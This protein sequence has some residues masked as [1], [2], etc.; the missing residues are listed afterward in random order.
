MGNYD[1]TLIFDTS[2]DTD[3]IHKGVNE[4]RTTFENLIGADIVGNLITEGVQYAATAIKD[5]AIEGV[6]LAS[7]LQEVE[8]VVDTTFGSGA[9]LIYSWAESADE[10]FGISELAAQQYTGT[11][12]SMLKSM[13]LTS[14][15]AQQMSTDM[16]GLAG[17]MASF[18]NL[19]V[20]TSFEKIRSGISG[21]TEPL[22][23]LGINMSVANLE[24]YALSRGIEEAYSAM[25]Q[26]EQA[27]LR[28]NYLMSVTADAQGDF[29]KTSEGYA[30]QQ[31]I[32]EMNI[33][34][35]SSTMGEQLLPIVNESITMFNEKLPLAEHHI[36]NIG[37]AFASAAEFAIENGTA[38]VTVIGVVNTYR[39]ATVAAT[40]A[41][42]ALNAVMSANPYTLIAGG[43]VAAV[44]AILNL[45][46]TE[47]KAAEAA[48][49]ANNAYKEQ[50]EVVEDINDELEINKSRLEELSQ[51]KFPSFADRQEIEDL[52]DKN[53]QL[54][55]QLALEKEI[56]A[57]KQ[58][59]A[60]KATARALEMPLES[61]ERKLESYKSSLETLKDLQ[62]EY[63]KAVSEGNAENIEQ[64]KRYIDNIT[65]YI[66][67]E[68]SV[69]M[70]SADEAQTLAKDLYGVTEEGLAAQKIISELNK[71]LYDTLNLG[72][73]KDENSQI[74]W[75]GGDIAA[76]Q[77]RKFEEGQASYIAALEAG[78]AKVIASE[79]QYVSDT[80]IALS[81][82]W[83][84]AEHNYAIGAIS[85][86]AELYR[87]KQQLWNEYGN[88][89]L[90][91]HWS[92]YEDLIAYQQDYAER[93]KSEYEQQLR[94][95]WTRIDQQLQLGL[96]SEEEAY[97]K[98]LAFI[99]K[100][101][102]EY[103][104]EWYDYYKEVYD[105]Q[106]NAADEQLELLKNSMQEQVDTV[107]E[108]LNDILSRYKDT[109]N[110][111]Q[112]NIDGYKNKLLSLGEA[113]SV[114]EN[115]D[116]SKTLRVNNLKE[117]MAEMQKY[118]SYIKK[119]KSQ[120]ASAGLL[121]ELTS[122]DGEEGFE[123]AK[124]LANMSSADFA[125]VNDY[126]NERDELAKEMAQEL[127][128]P[129]IDSLNRQLTDDVI[130]KFGELPEAVRL[131]GVEAVTAFMS[132][133]NEGNLSEQ[134]EGFANDF[135]N[136]L[137]SSIENGFS[138]DNFTLDFNALYE[139]DTYSVGLALG[140]DFVDG[141]NAAFEEL[142]TAVQTEQ[143]KISAEYTSQN[144]SSYIGEAKSLSAGDE[145]II[146][147]NHIDLKVDM[148]GEK[149]AEKVIEY[150]EILNRG[151]G[152]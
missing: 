137:S 36:E 70:S 84:T 116:G 48:E 81:Q 108:G 92:Y 65:F 32:F 54:E 29:A 64:Y 40:A 128:Q 112:S 118:H 75:Y 80:T 91:E 149:V 39:I 27:M 11:L 62:N 134:L 30:N 22:K 122:M 147:E 143:A 145:R 50:V 104:D 13:G 150:K 1:G 140:N 135:V 131:A 59:T 31:R 74:D 51:L 58:G 47:K 125:E 85:S 126:Y 33:Q 106:Q 119:L 72:T 9:T 7:S 18:Y 142:Q 63:D 86:E 151:K 44:A 78:K 103:S 120:G 4:I 19:D 10:S 121:A 42:T 136:E 89:N 17:D 49:T 53:E 146:L 139:Q 56:L 107:S 45:S 124:N 14:A 141:F 26:A 94:S 109:Y 60:D 73:G 20:S 55:I 8:N 24:A 123:F 82:A 71:E 52:K 16:T 144:R 3:G 133:I 68:K 28:Y 88:A 57:T 77:K 113:F 148:D 15:Q 67:E 41:Q 99:Q 127:Y 76:E 115:D 23:Q 138:S 132:G 97:K 98:K 130:A 2:I 110:D 37:A 35:L 12:G 95:E 43:A 83:N 105:Y 79:E 117:Q 69:L 111:I 114:I 129:E 5:F 93:S 61:Y 25:D 96:V 87:Q 66:E 34:T 102:P 152:K 38:I 101:C 46:D 100:Y 21:E 6:E 90:E